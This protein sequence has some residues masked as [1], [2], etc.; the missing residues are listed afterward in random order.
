MVGKL[1]GKMGVGSVVFSD[2]QQATGEF[3]NTVDN[4]GAGNAANAGKRCATMRKQGID[5]GVVT[6][7]G[8]RVHGHS[9]RFVDYHQ[10]R[11]FKNNIKFYFLRFDVRWLNIG[12]G[13]LV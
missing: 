7:A 10:M 8:S 3:I 6:I 11:I 5:K 4:A 12:N 13:Y 1:R 2:N 9:R